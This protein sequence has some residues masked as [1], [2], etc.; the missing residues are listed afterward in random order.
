MKRRILSVFLAIAMLLTLVP[1]VFA[2]GAGVVAMIG[3][4]QYESLDTAVAAAE[5]G[6][7]VIL[8]ESVVLT[9]EINI[10]AEKKITIDLNGKV[11][12]GV[13]SVAASSA[14]IANKG[15]LTI[16]DSSEEQTGKITSQAEKPD[17]EWVAGFPAYANNTITNSG[18]LTV[19]G[20]TIENTTTGGA[21]YAIDNNSTIADAIVVINGGVISHTTKVAIRQYANS[22]TYENSVTINGGTVVGGNRAV[23]MQLPGSSASSEKKASLTVTDGALIS[24]DETY[25]LAVYVYSFGDS[26]ANTKIDISGGE[27]EGNIAMYGT[28]STMSEKAVSI[29]G[30]TFDSAYGIFSYDNEDAAV[31]AISISGGTFKSDYCAFYAEDEGYAFYKNAEG[32]YGLIE[33]TEEE[34]EDKATVTFDVTPAD[35]VIKVEKDGVEFGSTDNAYDLLG[36]TYTY[37]VSK[38]GYYTVSGTFTVAGEEQA[39]SVTLEKILVFKDVPKDAY[40]AG[41]VAWAAE[42]EIAKGVEEGVFAPDLMCTR[43]QVVTFLWRA[44]GAPEASSEAELP[45]TDVEEGSYYYDA[46]VW[47]VENGITNGTTATTF[48]PDAVCTRAQVVTFLWRAAG[49]LKVE[50]E[51]PFADVEDGAYYYEAVVWAVDNGITNGVSAT[52]FAPAN[53]CTRAQAITLIYRAFDRFKL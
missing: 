21:C 12:S 29:S 38:D 37:T 8:Q 41:A 48:S 32:T 10:P 36:G 46:V 22:D 27:F 24:K 11:I 19:E 18:K 9:K 1:S 4:Q 42:N 39:I 30:G 13:S 47:A 23:W 16:T 25:N 15:E 40:F 14:V 20:G 17:T 44:A 6:E 45:F 50:A 52:E 53:D 5:N 3:E 34:I 49:E 43:A 28:A 26:G 35:A 51:M 33:T 31:A 7:V 2:D